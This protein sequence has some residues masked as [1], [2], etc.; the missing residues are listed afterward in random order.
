MRLGLND[1]SSILLFAVSGQTKYKRYSS[2]TIQSIF[3]G[4]IPDVD[5]LHYFSASFCRWKGVRTSCYKSK[6]ADL[7]DYFRSDRTGLP[8]KIGRPGGNACP[9][10]L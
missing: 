8:R 9:R 6:P 3:L 2:A 10:G 7:D 5:V 4:G 1:P